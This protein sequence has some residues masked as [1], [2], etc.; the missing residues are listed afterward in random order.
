[1]ANVDHVYGKMLKP[2]VAERRLRKQGARMTAQRH[3]VLEILSGNRTHPT[4]EQIVAGVRDRLGCVAPATIYNT[5]ETLEELGF[6]RRIDGLEQR[7]HFDPD[8]S[9]H[10]HAICLTCKRVWDVEP[11][12]L[13][14]DLPEDFEVTDILVQG[15]CGHCTREENEDKERKK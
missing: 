2:E 15:V 7:A 11:I 14:D 1:M 9:E 4:A 13:P 12:D 6:V 5:L 10:Q 8:T 3:A